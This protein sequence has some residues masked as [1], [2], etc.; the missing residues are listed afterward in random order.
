MRRAAFTIVSKNYLSFA[1]VLAAS[2]YR[3]H[4]EEPFFVILADEVDGYFDPSEEQFELVTI[5]NLELPGF[6]SFVFQYSIMELN[7]AVK[8]YAF[9]W[10]FDKHD[11]DQIIY[12]DPDIKIYNPLDSVFEALSHSEIALIPHMRRPQP[13]T[14][15][16]SDNDIVASGCYNLGF[17]GLARGADSQGLLDWWMRKLYRDCR[18]DLQSGLF[19]DQKWIDLVP[20]FFQSVAV[21]RA[22]GYNVAYWNLHERTVKSCNSRYLV[23][24][25]DLA[26]FHFSGYSP[27]APELLSRH[28]TRHQMLS[29][30][31]L[32]HL[33]DEYR[34]DL[35]EADFEA[36]EKFPYA[37]S[38]LRNGV[39]INT[40]LISTL[41][42]WCLA[43]GLRF[44]DPLV[45][46]D[47]FCAWLNSPSG[48]PQ[49]Q[50][51]TPLHV[52]VLSL[53][54]D[55]ERAIPDARRTDPKKSGLDAWMHQSGAT[56]LSIKSVL[57]FDS[58]ITYLDLVDDL[59]EKL[60]GANRRDVI[61]AYP[62]LWFGGDDM[63]EFQEWICSFGPAELGLESAHADAVGAAA[64]GVEKALN[65]YF[66]RA[67]LQEKFCQLEARS[68]S[69]AFVEW[70]RN[71]K[72]NELSGPEISLFRSYCFWCP[73]HIAKLR[74]IYSSF[75]RVPGQDP[76]LSSVQLLSKTK[77]INLELD[78]LTGWLLASRLIGAPGDS[79]N[80]G[81]NSGDEFAQRQLKKVLSPREIFR[82]NKKSRDMG[83]EDDSRLILN[84]AGYFKSF[85]GMGESVRSMARSLDPSVISAT[86]IALPNPAIQLDAYIP[87]FVNDEPES[88]GGALRR[89]TALASPAFPG[90]SRLNPM[91]S[92]ESLFGWPSRDADVS[93]VVA[94]ADS[95]RVVHEFLPDSFR[96]RVNVGYWVW[97]TETMPPLDESACARF[98]QIWTPSEHSAS[99]IRGATETPV[100]VIPHCL[101][102]SAI[103][104][105]TGDKLRYKISPAS[106]TF[107][108]FFDSRSGLERKNV[109]GLIKAFQRAFDP[110]EDAV[111]ILKANGASSGAYEFEAMKARYA[112][113]R[114]LFLDETLSRA[115]SL[116]FL[117]SLD[118]YVSLHR[119]EGFGLTLAEAMALG[120][121]VIATGYS[122]NMD[123][124][125][126]ENSALVEYRI[127]TSDIDHGPYAHGTVWADPDIED[128]AEKM[129]K[130]RSEPFRRKLGNAGKKSI[131]E[132]LSAQ[133]VSKCVS[134]ALEELCSDLN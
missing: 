30:T 67:D 85:T 6:S 33:C 72:L 76:S 84:L 32:R 16:P 35:F 111:L 131:R 100:R 83:R 88:S 105:V 75:G 129:Q 24:G 134:G 5:A 128:A 112:S 117:A 22:P 52:A 86:Y 71:E 114:I 21:L 103:D 108:F 81:L 110:T 121:P 45:V 130:M 43:K 42:Q 4:R 34:N 74:F 53:R 50:S 51:L 127:V 98:D 79:R 3:H 14:H 78:E 1:R 39:G 8:P 57:Q 69:E 44:P 65:V 93:V 63:T 61:E 123:F 36:T 120:I 62:E 48:C 92:P 116:E 46:P 104:G 91:D 19:V 25:E 49:F 9:R 37:F 101:D 60:K 7:T 20:G 31:T 68:T 18:V 133:R 12:L 40:A 2:W 95:V 66:L 55:V 122:G 13:E 87:D 90:F 118:V 94:N 38:T 70:L 28:Q 89:P 80:Q 97:E 102:F 73:R 15:R 99:A 59:F 126:D 109:N 106:L 58:D 107:G 41:I 119:A 82:L 17:I 96:A 47:E 54:P 29:G 56:E 10:L 23:D 27:Y 64:C 113:E 26:F 124:M 115:Q 132:K 77:S 11:F 125:T